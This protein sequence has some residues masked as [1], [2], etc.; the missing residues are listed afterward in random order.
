MQRVHAGQAPPSQSLGLML[1]LAH[2]IGTPTSCAPA[3]A[4]LLL[5]LIPA[6]TP[7]GHKM[8][9]KAP[10]PCHHVG[11]LAGLRPLAPVQA[12]AGM[13]GVSQQKE[14]QFTFTS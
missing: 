12:P 7:A 8:G 11:D 13:W 1:W 2:T 10:A 6:T 14:A 3:L 5:V 9:A 4:A